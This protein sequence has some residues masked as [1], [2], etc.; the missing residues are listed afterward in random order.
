MLF[1]VWKPNRARNGRLFFP[2]RIATK[3]ALP[4]TNPSECFN[5]DP[6]LPQSRLSLSC[7]VFTGPGERD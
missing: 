5:T 4:F 7:L 3:N 1:P 6:Q 2:Q